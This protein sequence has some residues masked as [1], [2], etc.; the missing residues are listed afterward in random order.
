MTIIQAEVVNL[1]YMVWHRAY[2]KHEEGV[3]MLVSAYRHIFP[4]L[5]RAL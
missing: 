3:K 1:G 5:Y 2:K 4:P